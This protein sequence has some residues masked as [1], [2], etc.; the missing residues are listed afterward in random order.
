MIYN[1][2]Q[3]IRCLKCNNALKSSQ[4]FCNIY[5]AWATINL[6]NRSNKIRDKIR[7]KIKNTKK[8]SKK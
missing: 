4:R 2:P 3:V 5:G 8:N 1:I 7:D 6:I